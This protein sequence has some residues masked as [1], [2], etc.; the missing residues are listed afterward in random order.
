L[1]TWNGDRELLTKSRNLWANIRPAAKSYLFF[2]MIFKK[3]LIIIN[4]Y[5]HNIY[6][7]IINIQIYLI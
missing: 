4:F 2:Y 3:D 5:S 7:Y 6:I 1:T